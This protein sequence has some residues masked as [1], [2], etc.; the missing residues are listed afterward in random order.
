MKLVLAFLENEANRCCVVLTATPSRAE[1]SEELSDEFDRP[2]MLHS[3]KELRNAQ[4]KAGD[5]H[6]EFL[7]LVKGADGK[8]RSVLDDSDGEC[9]PDT[10]IACLRAALP[11]EF[12]LYLATP[13]V[14]IYAHAYCAITIMYLLNSKTLTDTFFV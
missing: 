14:F 13:P 11:G 7:L 5:L 2:L 4:V 8:P 9:P 3:T 1:D 10:F 12:N 6:K